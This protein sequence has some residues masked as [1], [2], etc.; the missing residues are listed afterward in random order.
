MIIENRFYESRRHEIYEYFPVLSFFFIILYL[1]IIY[2]TGCDLR[3]RI[4]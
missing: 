1:R 4:P 3:Y 2:V